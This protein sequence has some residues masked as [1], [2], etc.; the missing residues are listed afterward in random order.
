MGFEGKGYGSRRE[1]N[2]ITNG[3]TEI[4]NVHDHEHKTYMDIACDIVFAHVSDGNNSKRYSQIPA[5]KGFRQFGQIAVA[6]MIKEFTQLNEG[7]VPG[8]PVVIPTNAKS[9]TPLEKNKALRA[10]NLIKEKRS[11]DINGRT[12]VDGSSQ[13]KYLKQDE[14]VA[15]PT[16]SLESLIATLLIDAYEGKDIAVYDVPGAYLQA[17]LAPK[18]SKERTLMKLEG[19]FVDIMVKVNPEHKINIIYEN[20]KKVMYLEILQAIYGCI[21]SVLRWYELYSETFIKEGFEI[22]PYDKCVANKVI[23]GKQCTIVWYIDDNKVSHVDKNVVTEVIE[24]M[25]RHFGDLVV[26]RG[27]KHNFLGMDISI[28][29]DKN[30]EIGMKDQLNEAVASFEEIEGESVSETVN[31][32]AKH[33]L[34]YVDDT[35]KKLNGTKKEVFHSVVQKLLYIMKRYMPDLETAVSYLCTRVSKSDIDDWKKLRT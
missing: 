25:K 22:N 24:L 12:C 32:S 13:R 1:F 26:T 35:C 33:H 15:S 9:L 30:I 7:A 5:K 3:T 14:S 6:A 31:S 23:N 11:G 29:E 28:T 20:G 10:V 19:E 27:K 8:K 16:A 34:R 4:H 17:I 21:E 18:R 2:L